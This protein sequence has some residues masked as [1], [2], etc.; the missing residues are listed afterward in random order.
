MT[1]TVG[2]AVRAV[3]TITGVARGLLRV[4]VL[5][6]A[7]VVLAVAAMVG[8]ATHSALATATVLAPLLTVTMLVFGSRLVRWRSTLQRRQLRGRVGDPQ[9][10][11]GDWRRLLLD[12]WA[13][14]DEFATA[15]AG[16]AGSALGE[17]L[18][19]H[20]PIVDETLVHCGALAHR[21]HRLSAQ[22]R[23]F[24]PRRLRRD[25][26]LE[27]RR[28][29]DGRRVEVLARQLDDVERLRADLDGV[30]VQ[31]E[32]QVHDLRTAAW[33]A[34]TLALGASGEPEAALR[35]LLADLDHLEAALA[36]VDVPD[37]QVAAPTARPETPT[38]P[39]AH[40]PAAPTAPA[41]GPKRHTAATS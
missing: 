9:T 17:R 5:Y 41:A 16:H 10:L 39:A 31:L 25:L 11:A 34:A 22:L 18:G 13:A 7:V 24:R 23:A 32:S 19:G 33:R 38:A 20:Q 35:D 36:E 26:L 15:V 6:V 21:G 3:D 2:R 27:R 40:H 4:V 37:P 12:A 28:G 8:F 1:A 29:R 30:R 14:R